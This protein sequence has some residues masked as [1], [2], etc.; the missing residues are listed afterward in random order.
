LPVGG[1]IKWFRRITSMTNITLPAHFD[2]E[3]IVLDTPYA[4]EPQTKL[5]VTVLA[6]P[7]PKDERS[8]WLQ[9]SASG[10]ANAYGPDEVEYSLQLIK[11]ANPEYEPRS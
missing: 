2:G 6:N 7:D 3:Q 8:D 5:L 1:A 9:A 11:K 4:L 10:L